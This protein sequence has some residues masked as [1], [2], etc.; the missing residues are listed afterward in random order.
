MYP[1]ITKKICNAVTCL[2]DLIDKDNHPSKIN[3]QIIVSIR[4]IILYKNI[5]VK[6]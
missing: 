5:K 4:K 6:M 3:L 2:G 1:H